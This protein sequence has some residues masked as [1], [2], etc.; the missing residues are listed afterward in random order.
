MLFHFQ[1]LKRFFPPFQRWGKRI[2][3]KF[4]IFFSRKSFPFPSQGYQLRI[5][6][7]YCLIAFFPFLIKFLMFHPYPKNLKYNKALHMP[8]KNKRIQ[9]FIPR[10]GFW[11]CALGKKF[12]I[13]Y[14][15]FFFVKILWRIIFFSWYEDHWWNYWIIFPLQRFKINRIKKFL[16]KYKNVKSWKRRKRRKGRPREKWGIGL[17]FYEMVPTISWFWKS[18][19]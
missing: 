19:P 17:F 2:V 1:H 16:Y 14:F 11:I 9:D 10:F 3:V 5:G 8:G 7:G 4:Q 12:K 13:F 15:I 6:C 18:S